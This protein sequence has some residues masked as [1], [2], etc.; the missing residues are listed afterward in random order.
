M[1]TN[2]PTSRRAYHILSSNQIDIM[3]NTCCISDFGISHSPIPSP[4]SLRSGVLWQLAEAGLIEARTRAE[5]EV[6]GRCWLSSV[7]S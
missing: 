4:V 1:D 5:A 3:F 2:H 6:P 7:D